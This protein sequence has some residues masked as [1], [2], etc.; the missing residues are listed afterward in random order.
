MRD[1]TTSSNTFS[2]IYFITLSIIEIYLTPTKI[3]VLSF[4]V[5]QEL[6]LDNYSY[7]SWMLESVCLW[8]PFMNI[9]CTDFLV[10][11]TLDFLYFWKFLFK[12]DSGCRNVQHRSISCTCSNVFS[13]IQIY[14]NPI[15]W[16]A[17]SPQE[18]DSQRLRV[19]LHLEYIFPA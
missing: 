1:G 8:S 10:F 13:I 19:C 12:L 2:C 15:S 17:N 5:H 11:S 3:L 7:P 4:W 18:L 9:F 6:S 14:L 16:H